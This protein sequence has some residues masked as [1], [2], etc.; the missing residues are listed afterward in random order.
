M[1]AG[2]F[3]AVA[4]MLLFTI[5]GVASGQSNDR[6]AARVVKPVQMQAQPAAATPAR[7]T[8]QKVYDQQKLSAGEGGT[9]YTCDHPGGGTYSC[10]CKGVIDCNRLLSSGDCKGRPI[11]QDGNDPS[12]GGCDAVPED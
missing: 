5:P 11:W 10:E 9:R 1:K 4:W 12:V 2:I 3:T 7:A 6:Q 8:R